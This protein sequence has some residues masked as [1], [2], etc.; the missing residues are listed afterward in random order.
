MTTPK[1]YTYCGHPYLKPCDGANED[2]ENKK[3]V[4]KQKAAHDIQAITP[5]D[6]PAETATP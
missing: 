5:E 3:H 2:C 4:D 6:Q 1:L